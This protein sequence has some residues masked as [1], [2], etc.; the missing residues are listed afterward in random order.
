MEPGTGRFLPDDLLHAMHDGFVRGGQTMS[1]V[2][3]RGV[4][5]GRRRAEPGGNCG[6]VTR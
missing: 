1:A 2:Q 3:V 4:M 6:R 5:A